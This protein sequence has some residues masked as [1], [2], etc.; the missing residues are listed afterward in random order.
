MGSNLGYRTAKGVLATGTLLNRV[1]PGGWVATFPAQ[2][3]PSDSDFEVYHAAIRGPGGYFLVF[4][5][6][7]HYGT[8]FNGRIDEMAPASAAMYIRKGQ[9]I[10]FHWSIASGQAPI[11]NIF[12]RE[13]EV[14]RI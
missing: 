2:V 9:E 7:T 14:G 4:I 12:L 3:L 8:A 5:D 10:S 13:P 1:T 6:N 11:A